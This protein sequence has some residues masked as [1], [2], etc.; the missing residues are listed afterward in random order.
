MRVLAIESSG[1][2]GSVALLSGSIAH[3]QLVVER[4]ASADQRTAQSLVPTIKA[5]LDEAAWRPRDVELVCVASGPGSFTGLRIGVV[6]AKTFAYAVGAKLV[7]VHTLSA[8]AAAV[9]QPYRRLWTI[10]DAQRQE[11]F[12]ACFSG[13]QPIASQAVPATEILSA[14]QLAARLQPG[15]AVAGPPLDKLRRQLPAAATLLDESLWRPQA[16]AVAALG[17]QLFEAGIE[18]SPIDLVPNYYRKSAAEEK[19]AKA[20]DK[21]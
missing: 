10:L 11:L 19:A 9:Q 3:P 1:R 17:R 16:S 14:S 13:D 6:A 20:R 5:A 4:Q 8:M 18:T 21:R 7:G 15:D 2:T 12:A